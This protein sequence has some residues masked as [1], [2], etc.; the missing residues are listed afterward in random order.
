MK[1]TRHKEQGTRVPYTL[2][3]SQLNKTCSLSL[4]PCAFSLVPSYY[5]FR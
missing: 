4:E 1:G 2:K 3:F 5:V